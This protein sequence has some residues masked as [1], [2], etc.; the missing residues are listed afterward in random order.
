MYAP[1][2]EHALLPAAAFAEH[3]NKFFRCSSLR[4]EMASNVI[5]PDVDVAKLILKLDVCFT[6]ITVVELYTKNI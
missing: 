5:Q 6:V 2:N 3:G 4:T 1:Y